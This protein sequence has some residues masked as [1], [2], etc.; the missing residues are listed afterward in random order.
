MLITR[1]GER[2]AEKGVETTFVTSS[3]IC[4]PKPK[5]L[6]FV[7]PSQIIV[8]FFCLKGT[9]AAYLGYFFASRIFGVPIHMKLNLFSPVDLAS[10]NSVI[11]PAKKNLE[12]ERKILPLRWAA[13]FCLEEAEE[14][15]EGMP[16]VE[17]KRQQAL[18]QAS[19][20]LSRHVG[21]PLT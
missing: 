11:G 18:P 19:G 9:K 21:E 12:G 6:R 13:G 4:D 10:V 15:A 3:L 8:E 5:P 16:T 2:K 1:D 7:K 20:T 14:S 17:P